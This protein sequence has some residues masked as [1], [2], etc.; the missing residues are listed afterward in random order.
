MGIRD[1]DMGY[2]GFNNCMWWPNH[3]VGTGKRFTLHVEALG[4]YKIDQEGYTQS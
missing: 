4:H 3:A 2:Y 1:A